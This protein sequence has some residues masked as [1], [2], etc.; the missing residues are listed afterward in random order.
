[1]KK[2]KKSNKLAIHLAVKGQ[3]TIVEFLRLKMLLES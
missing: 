2:V 3:M 1:M